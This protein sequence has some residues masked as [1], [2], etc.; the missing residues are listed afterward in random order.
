MMPF[1]RSYGYT[2]LNYDVEARNKILETG[3][4]NMEHMKDQPLFGGQVYRRLLGDTKRFGTLLWKSG[5]RP[6]ISS[7]AVQVRYL[8]IE[9]LKQDGID[10]LLRELSHQECTGIFKTLNKATGFARVAGKTFLRN[11]LPVLLADEKKIVLHLFRREPTWITLEGELMQRVREK[12][13]ELEDEELW[14]VFEKAGLK[15]KPEQESP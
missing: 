12:L 13:S 10:E 5:Y 11:H 8:A 3:R 6:N 2:A 7:L 9:F 4:V 14:K 15:R 1:A